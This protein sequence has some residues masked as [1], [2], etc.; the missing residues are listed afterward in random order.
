M[1]VAKKCSF[2]ALDGVNILSSKGK[3]S[4]SKKGKASPY[5]ITE[6]RIP[7]LIP[8]SWQSACRRHES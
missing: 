5:S 4:Q 2:F 1:R 6:R 7:E 8:G 3:L